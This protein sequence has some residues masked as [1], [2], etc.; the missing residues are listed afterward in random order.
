MGLRGIGAKPVKKTT[1]EPKFKIVVRGRTR[2]ERVISF[3]ESLPVTSGILAGN[4]FKLGQWQKKI[5]RQIYRTHRGRRVVRQAL[6]TIPRKNGKTT[7]TS[8]LALCH[9]CGPER[10]QRGEIY[11]AANE[12]NQAAIIFREMKAMVLS[13]DLRDRVIIRD[14]AKSLECAETGS[15]YT[16]LSADVQTKHG[17]SASF[18]AY[19]ELGQAANRKLYDVLNTSGGGRSE[20]L[21]IVISTQSPDP[22]SIMSELVADGERILAGSEHDPA[23]LPVIYSAPMDCDPWNEEVWKACN[24]GIESGFRSLDEMRDAAAKAKRIPAR[25]SVF[26][27]LYLNMPV[28]ID[29]RFIAL[30]D[31]QACGKS[32]TVTHL[33]G[34]PCFGGLDLS[35]TQDLTALVLYFPEDNGFVLPFFWVP[36]DRLEE[37]EHTDRVPYATWHK[38]GLIEAPAGRA[39]D[40]LAIVRRIAELASQYDIRGIAYDRWRADDLQKMLDDEGIEIKLTPWGQ[41][42]RDLGPCVD[43]LETAILNRELKHDNNPVLTWNISNAVIDMDPSGARKISKS[44]SREK[45]DALIALCMAIGLHSREPGARE[46]EFSGDLVIS[47]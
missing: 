42:F 40:R 2:A 3:I 21:G 34:R 36:R 45:V 4:R 12:R 9:L 47:A 20:P 5:I 30:E 39:I 15:I 24:P 16:A 14:F 29:D 18:W 33:E 32:D 26:K 46:I 25:E 23:F 13:T 22:H 1:D 43:L 38:Q 6:I 10:E 44:R 7:F 31:W 28:A 27:L 35:S 17:F 41:G 8:A 11:S 19:D 37:R